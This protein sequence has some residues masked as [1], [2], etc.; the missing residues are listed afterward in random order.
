MYNYAQKY[1]F[2]AS[3]RND[4][5][6]QLAPQNRNQIFWTAGAAWDITKEKFMN[7]QNFFNYLKLKGSIGVLGNQSIPGGYDYPIYPYAV[8]NAQ[9][10]FGGSIL[11]AYLPTM[12]S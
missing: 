9:A 3:I 8:S 2:T 7:S 10:V 4:A 1:F 12:V 5:T 6:S 11:N